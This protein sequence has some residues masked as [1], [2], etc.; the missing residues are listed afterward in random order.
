MQAGALPPGACDCHVHVFGRPSRYPFAA[1][2]AYT[3]PEASFR[4]YQAVM[5]GLGLTRAVLVQPSVYGTDN[6]AML[7]AMRHGGPAV[8][9][10]AVIGAPDDCGEDDLAALD[11]AG[12]RGVR[13]NTL[14]PGAEGAGDLDELAARIAPFGWHLQVLIDVAESAGL[15]KRLGS[16][17]VATVIDH[18]GHM[19]AAVGHDH[20]GFQ[21]LLALLRE[22][23]SWVKLSAPYRLSARSGPPYDDVR[24]FAEAVLEAAPDR[25]VWGSDWPHPAIEG[26]RPDPATLLDPL[27]DWVDDPDLRRRV[28]VDNP[29]RLYGFS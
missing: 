14:F 16:L 6:R 9:G 3:P 13:M 4:S 28:L 26:P 18:L 2:R 11:A 5:R 27:F 15:V 7:D 20:P 10:V 22:G 25:V 21:D 23:R 1:G 12:V 8:R 29:A 17:P 24:P 19:P